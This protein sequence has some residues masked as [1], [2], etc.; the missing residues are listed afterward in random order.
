MKQLYIFLIKILLF[1]NKNI[2]I[3]KNIIII[4]ILLFF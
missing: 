2:I 4:K 1:F 3:Y